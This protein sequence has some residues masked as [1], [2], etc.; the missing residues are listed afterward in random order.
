MQKRWK[1]KS[2]DTAKVKAL[3]DSLGI[4]PAICKILVQRNIDTFEKAKSYYRPQLEELH[5][6]WLMK[7]MHAAVSRIQSAINNSEN[8]LIFG[9]YDVDGTTAVASMYCFL[10]N[11]YPKVEFYIPNRYKEGYGVS[12]AGIDYAKTNNFSLIVSLDCGIKSVNLIAYAKLLNI[13]F[14]VC[15]HHLPDDTLPPAVAIR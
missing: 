3:S 7:D 8:I 6:P 5:S 13:D 9:D 2:A 15:D 10:K 11:I 1:I 12:K 4:N 14:I